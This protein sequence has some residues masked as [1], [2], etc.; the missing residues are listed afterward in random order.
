L[1]TYALNLSAQSRFQPA[2]SLHQKEQTETA[3]A[4]VDDEEYSALEL[5]YSFAE[6]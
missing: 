3:S 2:N 1:G 4:N 6:V 5:R